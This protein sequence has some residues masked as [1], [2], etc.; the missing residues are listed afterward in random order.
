[1]EQE[2]LCV[3][4]LEQEMEAFAYWALQLPGRVEQVNEDLLTL[5]RV[6]ASTVPADVVLARDAAARVY[7]RATEGGFVQVAQVFASYYN[8]YCRALL[9]LFREVS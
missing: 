3:S 4:P 8:V 6:G 5:Q 2:S 9:S 7:A 1:M